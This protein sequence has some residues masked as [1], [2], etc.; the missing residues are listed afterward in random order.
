[1]DAG[2]NPLRQSIAIGAKLDGDPDVEGEVAGLVGVAD[3][4]WQSGRDSGGGT[5]LPQ[6]LGPVLQIGERDGSEG[7]FT[8]SRSRSSPLG[9]IAE[10][11]EVVGR[12]LG[13]SK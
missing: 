7:L 12:R 6:A 1:M 5:S 3:S 4:S 9:G 10:G 2:R 11:L 13:Q 8:K